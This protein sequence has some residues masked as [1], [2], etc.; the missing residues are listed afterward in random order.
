M[1]PIT[2]TLTG[3][4]VKQAGLHRRSALLI[5]VLASLLPDIDYITRLWGTDVLLRYHRGITHSIFALFTFSLLFGLSFKSR[6]GFFYAFTLTFIC[7]GLHILFDLTNQYGTRVLAPLDWNAYGL[8]LTFIIEPWITIP[9][10]ISF[11]AGRLNKKRAQAIALL[12]F[13]LIAGVLTIRYSL[14]GEAKAFL[15]QKID[16]NIYRVY[17]IPNDFLTWSFLTKTPEGVNI[18][19]VDLFSKRVAVVETFNRP[20][21][22]PLI[23]ASK[24]SPVV[25]NFLYFAKYPY[26]EVL[27]KNGNVLV[28]WRELSFAYIAGNRFS[29]VVEFDKN[30]NVK[31]ARFKI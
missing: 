23:E 19:M 29:V 27:R 30:G 13:L 31:A 26:A 9:L 3:I 2:H 28:L 5:V 4:A 21:S 16:A 7:Y 24:R 1:D 10:L 8:D 15:K 14:Q 6:C 20:Q 22:D 12:T 18:G 25:Q 17:P 11:I